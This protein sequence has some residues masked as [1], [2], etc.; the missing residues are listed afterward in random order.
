MASDRADELDGRWF[1]ESQAWLDAIL[2]D[3]PA[4]DLHDVRRV[5]NEITREIRSGSTLEVGPPDTLTWRRYG[6]G[7]QADAE[8]ALKSR[9]VT[10]AGERET[11]RA[12][13]EEAMRQTNKV[14]GKRSGRA[15]LPF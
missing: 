12:K 13:A 9:L 3:Q 14:E 5:F 6:L 1:A 2:A 8:K 15:E 11:A 4:I 7:L 10:L